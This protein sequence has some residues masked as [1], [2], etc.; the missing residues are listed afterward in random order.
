MV[1]G[2]DEECLSQIGL[3]VYDDGSQKHGI[4]LKKVFLNG[5]ASIDEG[6]LS[7][8]EIFLDSVLFATRGATAG[9]N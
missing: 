3:V 5:S 1:E 2:D 8:H 7:Y 4:S 9:D 6:R